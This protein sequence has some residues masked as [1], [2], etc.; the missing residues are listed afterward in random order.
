MGVDEELLPRAG[1]P[2][3]K[4]NHGDEKRRKKTLKR[5]RILNKYMVI[6]LYR[7]Y[8]LPLFGFGKIFLILTTIGR[9]TGKKRRTPLEYHRID[10][11]ITVFSGR[12]EESGWMKNLRAN[13]EQTQIRHGFRSFKPKVEFII[14]ESKKLEIIKWYVTKHAKSAKMLF[15]WD[16]RLDAPDTTD[17]SKIVKMI[18][19][20][21]F[22]PSKS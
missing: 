11:M 20:I 12:G 4:L 10:D 16:R 5:W 22:Y 9:K 3:Y 6:P 7:S 2:L 8:V 19:I 15:G 17:F 1:S 13:P 18:S 21:R 14:S